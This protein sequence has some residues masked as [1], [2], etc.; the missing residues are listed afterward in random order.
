MCYL[1]KHVSAYNKEKMYKSR[2]GKER[3]QLPAYGAAVAGLIA[4]EREF[5]FMSG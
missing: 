5:N 3:N 1:I 4:S 2:R